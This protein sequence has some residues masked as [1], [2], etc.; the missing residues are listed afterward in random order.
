MNPEAESQRLKTICEFILAQAQK[1][2]AE[3]AFV[4]A[5]H[6]VQSRLSYEK[7][8]YNLATR[9]EG[10]GFSIIVH[11][12]MASGSAS[13]NSLDK[14][15]I[16]KAIERALHLAKH[17]I[18]DP[19]LCLAPASQYPTINVPFDEGIGQMDMKQLMDYGKLFVDHCTVSPKI[20][21]DSASIESGT[22][23]RIIANSKGMMACDRSSS[24]QWSVMG[25][26]ID[27][28]DITSF[29]FEGDHSLL[30]KGCEPKIIKTAELFNEKLLKCL[31]AQSGK[32]YQGR[33]ILSPA[34]VEEFLLDPL[35]FHIQGSNLM[36]D[37]S[38]WKNA[39]DQ[40]ITHP[41]LHLSDDPHNPNMRGCT[42]FSSEGVPTQAMT[43]LENGVLKKHL[44]SLYSANRCGTQAT[45]NGGGPHVPILK[46][47]KTSLDQL[48]KNADGP[49]IQPSRFS[50]NIDPVSGDFSGIAKGCQFYE[51]GQHQGPI[52]EI[53]ISGNVFDLLTSDLQLSSERQD[54]GG[55]Y[56]LPHILVDGVSV[57]AE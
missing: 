53:M 43:I 55:Y 28:D 42:P 12:N 23:V 38:R 24:L 48:I 7:G 15:Q 41:D 6:G 54:D 37:K 5:S 33:V 30:L 47:G 19:Y 14:T 11:K 17:S 10:S 25:M 52:R 45:G 20:S 27:G 34:L 32:S 44:Y 8:D 56:L 35:I 29:D 39:L 22:G 9:H 49:L 21:L 50:G 1:S 26:A 46:A 40:S 2:G 31:G 3:A 16:S 18:P 51:Q 36:D 13:I 4:S 57:T